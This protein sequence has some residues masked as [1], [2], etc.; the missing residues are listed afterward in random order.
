MRIKHWRKA[1]PVA[2]I[3]AA[4]LLLLTAGP[5][6][7]ACPFCSNMGKT[8]A[9]NVAE[10]GLVVYGTLSNAKVIENA[11]VGQPDGTT[12]LKVHTVIKSHPVIKGKKNIVLP[13][14]I[15][16][17][18]EGTVEYII[19]AEVIDGM[20]QPYNGMTV[21]D[22]D[23]V[24]YL[25][26]S[27]ELQNAKTPEK[28]A[29]YF[30]HL[31]HPDVNISGDAYKEFA[32][33]PYADI[34]TA[35]KHFSPDELIAWITDK[36]TPTYRIGLYGCLLGACGRE[37]DAAVLKSL[38]DDP[39]T[40]PLTGIDGLMGGYC[41]LDPKKGPDFVLNV[42]TNPE[43]DFNFRYAALRTI[44][45]VLTE[46]PQVDRSMVFA[47]M[48]KA[49]LISDISDLIIDEFRKHKEWS[50][51]ST[52]LGLYNK[53]EFDLQVIRRAIIRFA[54]RCPT[55]DAKTFVAKLRETEPQLVRDV[56]E[57]LKFE[58]AQQVQLGT[59]ASS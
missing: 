50:P 24:K 23:L 7:H 56:E 9:E 22:Q 51:I 30:K 38:I 28:L 58:E 42:L 54:L 10:A 11:A 25:A 14:F 59:S 19:F 17:A 12:D 16:S 13:R 46:M 29:F 21:D 39:E 4:G 34:E 57:V 36:N 2:A 55:Q 27:V 3:L 1:M 52:V 5:K 53:P 32:A 44:R 40:R 35:A 49:I 31:N 43:N 26:K 15:P 37:Q 47:K 6:A 41:V 8:L 18:S 20:I 48:E 33:T 45:F